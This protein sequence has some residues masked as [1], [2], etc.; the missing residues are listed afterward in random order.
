LNYFVYILFSDKLQSHYIGQTQNLNERLR[1]HNAGIEKYTSK[2]APWNL[3]TFVTV[4]TRSEAMKLERKLKNFKS[5]KR[6]N[7]WIEG[8]VG[9]EKQ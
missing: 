8:V 6:L 1:R 9:S 7:L 4:S 2:G 3:K 5:N